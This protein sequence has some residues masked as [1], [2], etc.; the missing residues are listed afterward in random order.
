MRWLD[1]VL[2]I[3]CGTKDFLHENRHYRKD[4][5]GVVV[6]TRDW[7]DR[8]W[9]VASNSFDYA[10]AQR[11]AKLLRKSILDESIPYNVRLEFNGNSRFQG[12]RVMDAYLLGKI[13]Y[14]E[15]KDELLE[16][17][18]HDLNEEM[19]AISIEA[20]GLMK[21]RVSQQ[22]LGIATILIDDKSSW[23]KK[24]AAKTLGELNNPVA[25]PYLRDSIDEI[26]PIIKDLEKQCLT[27][28][29][30]WEECRQ[31]SMILENAIVSLY[32]LDPLIGREALAQAMNSSSAHAIHHAKRASFLLKN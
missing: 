28:E 9:A 1:D 15:A 18:T 16:A 3:E 21:E 27:E 5:S 30:K 17:A 19:R 20:L 31:A 13:K 12:G 8:I 32:K 4:D 11:E 29:P 23:V 22:A 2:Q 14:F 6:P 7:P 10:Q 24:I 26:L 25:I